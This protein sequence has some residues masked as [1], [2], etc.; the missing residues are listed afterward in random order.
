MVAFGG[1]GRIIPASRPAR[2]PRHRSAPAAAHRAGAAKAASL[3]ARMAA[4]S[5][6]ALTAPARPIARVPTGM[7]AGICTIERRLSIP[8]RLTDS[9]GTPST[10]SDVQAAHIP[11]RCAAPPAP[12]MITFS[13]RSRA[14]VAYSR[15]R[16]GVR[17]AET[18]RIS[19][20]T[21]SCSSVAAAW[22]SV[23]QS[24]W[25][26]MMIATSRCHQAM[27]SGISRLSSQA[28]S[29]FNISL[30]FFSRCRCS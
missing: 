25:L 21:A 4:A 10:G 27:L 3:V 12:A 17:C 20:V 18:M 5:N 11:G 28:I 26:P 6:A 23:A 8:L 19:W 14:P 29:S 1:S 16:S 30:R 9:T 2:P 15:S 24:D 22:R 13:P 7:P